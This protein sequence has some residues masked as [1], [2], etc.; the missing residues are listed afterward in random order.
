MAPRSHGFRLGA[1]F[2]HAFR[3]AHEAKDAR[4]VVDLM[5]DGERVVAGRRASIRSQVTETTL[6]REIARD[7]EMLLNTVNLNSTQ[8]LDGYDEV[9]SSII[10]FG[11]PDVVHRTIDEETLNEVVLE[12]ATALRRYEPR[13]VAR[14][15]DVRRDETIDKA[16]LKVRFVVAAEIWMDPENIPVEFVANVEVDSGKIVV[17]QA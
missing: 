5:E 3:A 6:R 1:P 9:S 17:S 10:N 12:L 11:I 13:I 7:L 4:K 15:L 14:T 8:R 16:E 2:M